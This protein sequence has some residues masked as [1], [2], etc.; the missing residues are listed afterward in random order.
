MVVLRKR[1]GVFLGKIKCGGVGAVLF[2]HKVLSGFPLGTQVRL[3]SGIVGVIMS[4]Y[5]CLSLNVNPL[6]NWR[7]VAQLCCIPPHQVS[8]RIVSAQD[9]YLLF[10]LKP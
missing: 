5:G 10:F 1:F 8:S 7:V 2:Q 9:K 3:I 4:F 6:M